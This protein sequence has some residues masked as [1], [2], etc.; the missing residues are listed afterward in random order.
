MGAESEPQKNT[1]HVLAEAISMP[2][3]VSV[4][5]PRGSLGYMTIKSSTRERPNQDMV[6]VLETPLGVWLIVAD[7]MGGYIDTPQAVRIFREVLEQELSESGDIEQVLIKAHA[8][9]NQSI[10]SQDSAFDFDRYKAG[11][12]VVFSTALLPWGKNQAILHQ[13]G[14]VRIIIAGEK[15]DDTAYETEDQHDPA[16]PS[17]VTGCLATDSLVED[18]LAKLDSTPKTIDQ[19]DFII[20]CSDGVTRILGSEL[21]LDTIYEIL[22]AGGSLGEAAEA[23]CRKSQRLGSED[24]ITCLIYQQR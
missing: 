10:D 22:E 19:N 3:G 20:L 17:H 16:R 14:D 4:E 2:E 13:L 24:D 5:L 12:G 11:G 23:V 9:M 6:L 18:A 8:R 1:V 15:P 21:I 7:G